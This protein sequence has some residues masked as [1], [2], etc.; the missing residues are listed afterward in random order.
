ML[1][2]GTLIVAALA[3]LRPKF[4]QKTLKEHCLWLGASVLLGF[5]VFESLILT[6]DRLLIGSH[7][8]TWAITQSVFIKES[9]WAI[10]LMLIHL[11]FIRFTHPAH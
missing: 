6:V 2:V 11:L 7:T 5:A 1:G 3:S 8:L 4:S 9:V 10:G